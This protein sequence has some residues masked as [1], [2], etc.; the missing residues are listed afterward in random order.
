MRALR[1]TGLCVGPFYPR[2]VPDE[3]EKGQHRRSGGL[4]RLPEAEAE[5]EAEAPPRRCV[6]QAPCGVLAL[7]LERP[8]RVHSSGMHLLMG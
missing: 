8:C 1:A 6:A 5:A 3:L 7:E 2:C 4:Q